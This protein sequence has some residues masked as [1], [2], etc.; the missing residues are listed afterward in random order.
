MLEEFTVTGELS[1][2]VKV[3]QSSVIS[4][5]RCFKIRKE[6]NCLKRQKKLSLMQKLLKNNLNITKK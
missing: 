6:W 3:V 2:L 5:N 1:D 4:V